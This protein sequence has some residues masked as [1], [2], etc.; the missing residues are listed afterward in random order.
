MPAVPPRPYR[1]DMTFPPAVRRPLLVDALL[2]VF[3][4]TVVAF[5]AFTE[6][7]VERPVLHA[8]VGSLAML[9]M[10]WR[11]NWP[12]A[13]SGVVV[14]AFLLLAENGGGLSIVLALLIMAFTVG[15]ET[16]GRR[17]WM[18][19]TLLLVPFFG[20]FLIDSGSLIPGDVAA[21]LV[22]IAG[23]WIAGRTLR[24][25]AAHL[26]AAMT[27]AD[28]LEQ[29]KAREADAATLR[30]RTRLARELHDIVSH[31][32][33]VIAIQSQAVRRRL[34]PD[35]AKEAAD[36]AAVETAAREAMAEMR[37]LFGVL[38]EDGE[39]AELAPQ[40]GLAE[41]E[42]LAGR[43]RDTGMQMEVMTAGDPVE[44]SPGVDLA[45]YRIVQEAVT[46]ALRHSGA[47]QVAV[48]LDY[49]PG[50]LGVT[51][52]DDGRGVNGASHHL[53][54]GHGLRGIRERAELYGGTLEI[55][56]SDTGGT[57]VRARLP[58]GSHG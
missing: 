1:D 50:E 31:S 53:A 44:L 12:I 54:D 40:P 45:A 13:V 23:P 51:V 37:R 8:V 41:L 29:E 10:M 27:R 34:G 25:R 32:I 22:L 56:A 30:E 58:M 52:E 33:S 38:R 2:A 48:R 5:E 35:H 42:R 16:D 24:A 46:N 57:R 47:R 21:G 6:A 39:A 20:A 14:S 9:A 18:G 28:L 49:T 3:F 4:A 36:L 55:G 7:E 11:R 19:V 26:A 43:V 17:S 15:S